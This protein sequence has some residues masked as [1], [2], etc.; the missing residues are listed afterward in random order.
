[1]KLKIDDPFPETDQSVS[2]ILLAV[3]RSYVAALGRAGT[4]ARARARHGGGIAGN[5]VRVLPA[6][7][8]GLDRRGQ[9]AVAAAVSGADARGAGR[10]EEMRNVF[11]L[12]SA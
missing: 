8:D 2:Q 7:V 12:G 3:H 6:G 1:M 4:G 5:L 9:L 10:R 11:N